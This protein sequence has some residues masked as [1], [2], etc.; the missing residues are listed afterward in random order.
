M[1]GDNHDLA[2]A[3]SDIIVGSTQAKPFAILGQLEVVCVIGFSAEYMARILAAPFVALRPK[4]N[5]SKKLSDPKL[6]LV[7]CQYG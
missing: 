3:C 4:P 1:R 7:C 5:R 6:S 2:V